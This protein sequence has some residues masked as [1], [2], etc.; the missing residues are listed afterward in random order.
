[1]KA[2]SQFIKVGHFIRKI[3]AAIIIFFSYLASL[4][5]AIMLA[6]YTIN[7]VG[8][9]VFNRPLLGADEMISFG[10]GLIV[11]LGISYTALDK[12]HVE[13]ELVKSRLSGRAQIIMSIMTSFLGA[14]FW[15]ILSWQAWE[16]FLIEN[17]ESLILE[18]PLAPFILVMSIGC[19]ILSIQLAIDCF[20]HVFQIVAFSDQPE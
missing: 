5:L 2:F 8:R 3:I 1:M 4:I 14:A 16:R 6:A 7:V 15:G 18:I 12:G 11:F 13:I 17:Q 9:Y 10:M 19:L 20:S